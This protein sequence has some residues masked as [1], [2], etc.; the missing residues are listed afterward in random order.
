M[1]DFET[2]NRWNI[3]YQAAQEEKIKTLFKLF[4]KNNIE[5]ILIK[6]WSVSRYFPADI[7]RYSMDIDLAV[8]ARDYTIS[9]KLAET[10]KINADIHK[11]LR[12]LEALPYSTLY[13]NSQSVKLNNGYEIRILSVEDNLRV[14]CVHWL[15]DGGIKKDRLWDIY[16]CVKNRPKNF[17]WE[18]CLKVAGKT[19]RKWILVTI[20]AAHKYLNLPIEDLPF[21]AEINQPNFVPAWFYKTLEKEWISDVTLNPINASLENLTTLAK[22]LR[23]RFP[24]NPITATI[25]TNSKINNFPR[26][27]IQLYNM[28]RRLF[29]TE[30]NDQSP[31]NLIINKIFKRK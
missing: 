22:Q 6:G 1:Q 11:E 23:K 17:D 8:E 4:R 13:N 25:Q 21:S 31:F 9:K 10:V 30:T 29:P 5:P 3:I 14:I 24:P 27:P 18:K 20:V 12:H 19:R 26:L 2:D 28:C 16:Y 15:N 7:P